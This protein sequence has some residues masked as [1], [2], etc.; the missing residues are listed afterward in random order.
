MI[1]YITEGDIYIA[2]MTQQLSAKSSRHPYEIFR[3]LRVP[4]TRLPF[5]CYLNYGDFQIVGASPERFMRMR[6]DGLRHG[7]SRDSQAGVTPEEDQ[8][9]KQELADSGKDKK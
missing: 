9:L 7:R 1:K 3:Y 6:T 5:G 4:T 8:M 2:N